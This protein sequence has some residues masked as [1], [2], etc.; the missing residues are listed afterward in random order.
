MGYIT[1]VSTVA[2]GLLLVGTVTVAAESKA[3]QERVERG[4]YLVKVAGCNDC[5]T[6]GYAPAAGAV[7]ES[8]WLTGDR[9]GMAGPWG[10]T[11]PTNLR[12]SLNAMSED[13]WVAHARHLETRPP[14]PWFA[15]H[16]MT[17]DDLRAI[18]AF[19]TSLGPAG[20]A[21]PAALPPGVAAEG[22]VVRFP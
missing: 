14:M 17:D 2:A 10:T 20:Q 8:L 22:P 6:P 16:A 4:R 1:L 18:H 13:D 3:T 12:L 11:Y 9:L 15:L 7:D 5:H 19:V 21:A